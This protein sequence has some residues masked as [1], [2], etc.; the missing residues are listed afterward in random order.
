[1]HFFATENGTKSDSVNHIPN[2]LY[3][4][5]K[6]APAPI[7]CVG[8]VQISPARHSVEIKSDPGGGPK[9]NERRGR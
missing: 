6:I 4:R 1:M 5:S 9:E 8:K 7:L 2:V 3:A